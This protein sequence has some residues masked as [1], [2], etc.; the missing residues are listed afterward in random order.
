MDGSLAFYADAL[1]LEVACDRVVN[2]PNLSD[3]L[4]FSLSDIRAVHLYVPGGGCVGLLEYH[5]LETLPGATRPCDPGSGHVCFYVDDVDAL[6]ECAGA[7]GFRTRGA[8][9]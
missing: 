9:R 2:G 7:A 3:V 5:G 4:G 6:V 1:G 8:G